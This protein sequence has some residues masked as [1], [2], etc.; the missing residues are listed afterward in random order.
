MDFDEKPS[1]FSF[2]IDDSSGVNITVYL[3]RAEVVTTATGRTVGGGYGRT[4]YAAGRYG[5]NVFAGP[6][7]L[8]PQQ[9]GLREGKSVLGYKVDIT[10]VEIGNVVKVKGGV[11]EWLG[12]RQ[13]TLERIC[14]LRSFSSSSYFITLEALLDKCRLIS[15]VYNQ[16]TS[17]ELVAW[18]A[19]ASLY[20]AVLSKPWVLIESQVKRL[21]AEADGTMK[22]REER[23]KRKR[24]REMRQA[25]GEGLRKDG[26]RSEI[27]NGGEGSTIRPEGKMSRTT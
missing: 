21:K 14:E 17:D 13:L 15:L 11:G 8:I 19:A 18:S 6:G 26:K 16:T 1:H 7:Q 20:E 2:V 5:A 22:R 23:R 25:S 9:P 24:E 4:S 12:T 10:G 27:R 3:P